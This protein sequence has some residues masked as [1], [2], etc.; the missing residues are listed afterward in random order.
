MEVAAVGGPLKKYDVTTPSGV[1]TTMKLNE[2][3]AKR[4]GVLDAPEQPAEA[5]ATDEPAETETP[6]KARTT[7]NK[8]RTASSDK[9][10][11]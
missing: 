7:R 5:Q 9:G 6:S 1:T 8:A 4:L 10:D 3:D 2:D 11:G